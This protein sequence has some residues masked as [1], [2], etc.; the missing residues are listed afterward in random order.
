M[1]KAASITTEK[2]RASSKYQHEIN[3]SPGINMGYVINRDGEYS[4]QRK[5]LVPTHNLARSK[6]DVDEIILSLQYL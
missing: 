4:Q 1:F 3:E 5:A 2:A 6:E